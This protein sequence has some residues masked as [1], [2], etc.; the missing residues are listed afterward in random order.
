MKLKKTPALTISVLEGTYHLLGAIFSGAIVA[1]IS[2]QWIE[3]ITV[4][5]GISGLAA[6]L[7]IRG[8]EQA[9]DL[10]VEFARSKITKGSKDGKVDKGNDNGNY[11]S[12]RRGRSQ[13]TDNTRNEVDETPPDFWDEDVNDDK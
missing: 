6:Y 1:L 12:Q 5:G 10:I 7:G 3:S 11:R 2:N 8:V 13:Q 9:F 4:I